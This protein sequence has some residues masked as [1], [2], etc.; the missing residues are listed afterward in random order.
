MRLKK[1]KKNKTKVGVWRP[2]KLDRDTK[3]ENAAVFNDSV[4]KLKSH[5]SY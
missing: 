3:P 4:Q 2:N 5:L 1:N